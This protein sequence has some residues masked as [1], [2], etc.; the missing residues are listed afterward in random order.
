[1]MK[2]ARIGCEDGFR[3]DLIPAVWATIRL[4]EPLLDTVVAKNMLAV[5]QTKR[6]FV[7]TLRVGDTEL[8]VADNAGCTHRSALCSKNGSAKRNLHRSPSSRVL[9]STLW[10]WPMAF[11]DATRLLVSWPRMTCC[12]RMR[13]SSSR[14]WKPMFPTE[15]CSR[16]LSVSLSVSI[17]SAGSSSLS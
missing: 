2:G 4:L 17:K 14:P 6:G 13:S 5:R 9:I 1:M 11:L 8:I 7:D 3:R 10:S 16:K 12:A 15:N